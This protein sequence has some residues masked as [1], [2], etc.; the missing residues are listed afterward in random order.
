M[1]KKYS[2]TAV[3]E[4][5]RG[6]IL[7]IGNNSYVKTHPMQARYAAMAGEPHKIYLH[8]EIAAILKCKDIEK[9]Y[10]LTVYRYLEDGTPAP[11]CPCRTCKQ[12]IAKTPIKVV[13]HT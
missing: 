12:A 1:K 6:N 13:E 5:R 4:D 3:I 2:I 7:S 9:A 8:A 11:A 10:K